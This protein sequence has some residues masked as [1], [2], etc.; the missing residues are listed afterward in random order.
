MSSI[1]SELPAYA[2]VGLVHVGN[3]DVKLALESVNLLVLPV[4]LP[5]HFGG[6]TLE[7]A[8]HITHGPAEQ[9]RNVL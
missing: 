5:A 3:V 4:Q 6:Q 1:E 7:V 9:R 8:Q 2:P